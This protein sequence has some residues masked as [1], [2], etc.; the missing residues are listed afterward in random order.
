MGMDWGR[1]QWDLVIR[2]SSPRRLWKGYWMNSKKMAI[3]TKIEE[4]GSW[5]H[6][7]GEK[8]LN[9]LSTE[10][11]DSAVSPGGLSGWQQR[12]HSESIRSNEWGTAEDQRH[13]LQHSIPSIHD[14][15]EMIKDKEED[16]LKLDGWE[17]TPLGGGNTCTGLMY[18]TVASV[19]GTR[20]NAMG[21]GN[22]VGMEHRMKE[23]A[24]GNRKYVK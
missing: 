23:L 18:V 14:D 2:T 15:Q 3:N 5:W 22:R 4:N 21:E 20:E 1:D 10:K 7:L 11:T 8:S 13:R 9:S 19:F 17:L 6:G 12:H 16:W 24:T